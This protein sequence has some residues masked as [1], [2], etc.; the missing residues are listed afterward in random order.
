[1]YLEFDSKKV[2]EIKKYTKKVGSQIAITNRVD[3]NNKNKEREIELIE[4]E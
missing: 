4:F 1:M 3:E 2:P